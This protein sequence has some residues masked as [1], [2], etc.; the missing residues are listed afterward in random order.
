MTPTNP[1]KRKTRASGTLKEKAGFTIALGLLFLLLPLLYSDT[2]QA[3]TLSR[4]LLLPGLLALLIG[5]LLLAV[6]RV[7]R[8][9]TAANPPA[10]ATESPQ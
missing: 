6:D 4:G 8:H 2:P 5:A 3:D 9:R 10:Q 1:K 7:R